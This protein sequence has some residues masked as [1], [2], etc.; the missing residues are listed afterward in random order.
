MDAGFLSCQLYRIHVELPDR[1]VCIATGQSN[2]ESS[3]RTCPNTQTKQKTKFVLLFCKEWEIQYECV[4]KLVN[5]CCMAKTT[6]TEKK[7]RDKQ[8][9]W[10]AN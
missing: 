4:G 3:R 1:I 5:H 9:H 8:R 2:E 10:E 7:Q 6:E